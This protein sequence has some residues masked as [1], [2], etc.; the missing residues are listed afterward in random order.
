MFS[1]P[2]RNGILNPQISFSKYNPTKI[3]SPYMSKFLQSILYILNIKKNKEKDK[4]NYCI[5][6]SNSNNSFFFASIISEILF[7]SAASS[8]NLFFSAASSSNFFFFASSS[9]FFFCASSS[10][11]FFCASSSFLSSS[12]DLYTSSLKISSIF[13]SS[14]SSSSRIL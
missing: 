8:S 7:F 13:S 14:S 6:P 9:N 4:I 5:K 2:S 1:I 3:I 11:F 12:K 10:N